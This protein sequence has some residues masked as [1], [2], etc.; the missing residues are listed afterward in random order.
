[1]APGIALLS[2]TLLDAPGSG[3][4]LYADSTNA[5]PMAAPH[6]PG[7]PAHV[8]PFLWGNGMEKRCFLFLVTT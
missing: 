5:A 6:P 8:C 3:S 2:L 4:R 1:M 7:N